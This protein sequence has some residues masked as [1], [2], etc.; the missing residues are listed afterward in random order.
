MCYTAN[1]TNGIDETRFT[2]M[3]P[4]KHLYPSLKY[5]VSVYHYPTDAAH[6]RAWNNT[7]VLKCALLLLLMC[8]V[9]GAGRTVQA[10][11]DLTAVCGVVDAVRYPLDDLAETTLAR[12]YDD[13]A[14]FRTNF[15]GNHTGF[16]M[17]FNQHGDPVRAMARGRVTYSD[18]EGWDTEKGVVIIE[19]LFPDGSLIYSLYGHI[20]EANDITLP[21]LGDCV[22]MGDTVGAVGWPSRGAPHLHFEVRTFLPDD[23]GPGYVTTNPL[24]E[25][26][27]HPLDFIHLWQFRLMPAFETYTTF[28]DTPTLPPVVQENGVVVI[29]SGNVVQAVMPP[30]AVISRITTDGP[31]SGLVRL[32]DNRVVTYTE[33]GQT[34]ILTNGRFSALWTVGALPEA[35][36]VLGEVIV[37]VTEGGGLEAY[38]PAGQ[39]LWT[40]PPLAQR[41]VRL[42]LFRGSQD[43]AAV[44]VIASEGVLWRVV[45][46]AGE[47]LHEATY[48]RA[49][50]VAPLPGGGWMLLADG[51][52]WRIINGA[53]FEVAPVSEA[54]TASA[55]MT[56]D[57][58]GNIYAFLGDSTQTLMSW[59]P[60]GGLR[61]RVERAVSGGVLPPLLRTDN[62]CLLYLLDSDGRLNL[63]EASSG[64]RA[65]QVTFYA[66]GNQSRRPNARLLE[67][68]SGGHVRVHAGFLTT[69]SLD[70]AVLGADVI[71]ACLLG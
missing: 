36:V 2:V 64:E 25:G 20:E 5:L 65:A 23:G 56:V 58:V 38:D 22:A 70:G 71:D 69:I 9:L 40:A 59:S 63:Y 14:R 8:A 13:F 68:D 50:V 19:H 35:P 4:L 39:Q 24:R 67:V 30:A 62:G 26:W 6:V 42:A 29:A 27:L 61:W 47:I 15:G 21:R 16:D 41:D 51:M 43:Q 37:F 28:Q 49:P 18:I 45:N 31:V 57:T 32:P 48:Q 12:G 10:Q 1:V 46:A 11:A 54:H 52:L 60:L 17:G 55:R 7:P 34:A 33:N 3:M 66:G 53:A 44:A